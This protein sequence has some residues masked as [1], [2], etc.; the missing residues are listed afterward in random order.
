MTPHSPASKAAHVTEHAAAKINLALH[1]TGQRDDGYHLLDTLV[2]FTQAGDMVTATPSAE[3]RFSMTGAFADTLVAN[4]DNLVLRAR[5]L[6]RRLHPA[7]PPVA[8]SLDKS[9]PV[10]SGIG[11]GSADAAAT[12][13]VLARMLGISTDDEGLFTAS[14]SLGADVPMC[15]SSRPARVQGIGEAMTPVLGLPSLHLVL[16]NPGVG[17]STP[18]VFKVLMEKHNTPLPDL[19]GNVAFV[20][21]VEWLRQTRNDLQQPASGQAPQIAD[22]IAA[23]E[24]A[25]AALARM[26]GSGATCFGLFPTAQAAHGAAHAI[27]SAAPTWYVKATRTV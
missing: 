11:G 6:M 10:A 5:A 8:L 12:L 7:L 1:I 2:V 24:A 17:V 4:S 25:G 19:P 26:S 14:L 20:P 18:S 15:L 23:L 3:D 21:F 9:L 22:A 27:A 13:R 16:I